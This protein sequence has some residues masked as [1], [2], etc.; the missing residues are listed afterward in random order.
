MISAKVIADS[1]NSNRVR[2]TTLELVYPKFIHAEFMTHRVFSRNASSSR[3]IPVSRQLKNVMKNPV[4]PIRWGSHA[5]GM[6]AGEDIDSFKQRV[7]EILWTMHRLHSV[8]VAYLLGKLGVHKQHVNRLVEAHTLIKVVVTSTDWANFFSL[9]M[10]EDVQPE[11]LSLAS[12]IHFAMESSTPYYLQVDEWH[13]PYITP[14]D[15]IDA[16]IKLSDINV[17]RAGQAVT[18]EAVEEY[19]IYVSVARCARVSYTSFGND[20]RGI[21]DDFA[22]G[23]RLINTQPLHASPMEHQAKP[24]PVKKKSGNLRGWVQFRKLVENESV[25]DKLYTGEY[26]TESGELA[27]WP[28]EA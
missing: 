20:S 22:L 14:T 6:Q 26:Y 28:K 10:Q 7:A 16:E 24:N 25:S 8:T 13:L 12:D 3:A 11:M 2:L 1:V 18:D 19:L 4:S 27:E 5:K 17:G 21:E 23:Q 15:R 9:R